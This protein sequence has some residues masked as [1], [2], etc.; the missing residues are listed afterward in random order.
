MQIAEAVKREK[1]FFANHPVYSTIPG[2]IFGTL[3]LTKKLTTILYRRIRSFLPELMKEI[4]N[5]IGK[6]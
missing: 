5:R 6:I 2:E 4:N 1:N 3:V